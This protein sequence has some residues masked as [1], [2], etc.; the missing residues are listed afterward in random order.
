[1][2]PEVRNPVP[3]ELSWLMTDSVIKDFFWLHVSA[4][5]KNQEVDATCNNNH[6]TVSTTNV[7]AAS[8]LLDGRLID[9]SQPLEVVVNGKTQK[10]TVKRSLTTLCRTL[11]ERG[12]PDLA[13]SAELPLKF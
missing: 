5:E 2:Y 11:A 8:V 13:F 1:M 6:L 12:D 7:K 10:S 9:F 4:P 3:R